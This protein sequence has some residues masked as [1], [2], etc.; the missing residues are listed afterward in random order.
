ML[1]HTIDRKRQIVGCAGPVDFEIE[2]IRPG[3]V[4]YSAVVD[5]CSKLKC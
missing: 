1:I 3:S 2:S 5:P 4:T